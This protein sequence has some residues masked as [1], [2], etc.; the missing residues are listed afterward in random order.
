VKNHDGIVQVKSPGQGAVFHVYLPCFTEQKTISESSSRDEPIPGG[1]ERILFVDDEEALVDLTQ[2][3]LSA[4]GYF[5]TACI[6]SREAL[7]IYMSDPEGFDLIITDMTMPHLSGSEL[8]QEII[9]LRPRQPIILCTG[10]SS[11]I[12]AEKA[13]E[14]GIKTFLFKPLATR[15]LATAVRKALDEKGG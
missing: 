13:A 15:D 2:E 12:D 14:M 7:K 4:L 8:A 3:I 6:D 5:V 10:Y 1:S 11:F 9:K